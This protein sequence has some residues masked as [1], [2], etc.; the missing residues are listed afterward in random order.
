MLSPAAIPSLVKQNGEFL[1]AKEIRTRWLSGNIEPVHVRAELLAQYRLFADIIGTPDYWNSHENTHVYPG[2]F[3]LFVRVGKECGMS[4]MRSHRRVIVTPTGFVK[5]A[6]RVRHPLF[7]VKG[8]VIR[9]YSRWAEN[10]GMWMPKGLVYSSG[11]DKASQIITI[12]SNSSY[13]YDRPV[14][15]VVHPSIRERPDLFGEVVV[16]RVTEYNTLRTKT[17][18]STLAEAKV[19]LITFGKRWENSTV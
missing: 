17:F 15:F 3:S 5:V 18:H 14:E 6:H 11:Y 16:S 8:L 9:F 7:Y 12:L 1:S 4:A 10:E 19:K 2:L 13:R